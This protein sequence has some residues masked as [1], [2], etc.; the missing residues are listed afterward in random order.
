MSCD[1]PRLSGLPDVFTRAVMPDEATDFE[2]SVVASVGALGRTT[3]GWERADQGLFSGTLVV[4]ASFELPGS[5]G[6]PV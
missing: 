5:G 2:R 3:K 6:G 1:F 4:E